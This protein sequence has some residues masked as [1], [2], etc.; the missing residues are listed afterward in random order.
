MHTTTEVPT[1]DRKEAIRRLTVLT[2]KLRA[3][4]LVPFG[5]SFE[6]GERTIP[7]IQ[8]HGYLP[9]QEDKWDDLLCHWTKEQYAKDVGLRHGEVVHIYVTAWDGFEHYLAGTHC[10]WVGGPDDEPVI[11]NIDGREIEPQ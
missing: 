10:G 1:Y 5:G 8:P 11:V 7:E 4:G 3:M 9:G 2:K 6:I